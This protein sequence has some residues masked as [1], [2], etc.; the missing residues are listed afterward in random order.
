MLGVG[1]DDSQTENEEPLWKQLECIEQVAPDLAPGVTSS[2]QLL[3]G[4]LRI[5]EPEEV[6]LSFNG[7]KDATVVFH[8]TRAAFQ[9]LYKERKP[10][11]HIQAVFFEEPDP[12]EQFPEVLEFVADWSRRYADQLVFDRVPGG[13]FHG[14]KTYLTE[15]RPRVRCF[16]LGTR[17]IDPDGPSQE[18]LSPS[19]PEWPS[20]LRVNPILHWSYRAVWRFLRT[21][22]LEYCSLYDAG[23]TSIGRVS[24]TERNP[25]LRRESALFDDFTHL[26]RDED[27]RCG[28]KQKTKNQVQQLAIAHVE[29]RH[30]SQDPAQAALQRLLSVRLLLLGTD[31]SRW[32]DGMIRANLVSRFLREL[33]S[34]P[35][36]PQL[37]QVV[38]DWLEGLRLALATSLHGESAE[39]QCP[40]LPVILVA[41]DGSGSDV[42]LLR[43]LVEALACERLPAED[44]IRSAPNQ[45]SPDDDNQTSRLRLLVCPL[46]S[47]WGNPRHAAEALHRAID[48]STASPAR[49]LTPPARFTLQCASLRRCNVQTA[50][51]H[52]GL[53]SEPLQS[54]ILFTDLVDL[55]LNL[56]GHISIAVS[57]DARARFSQVFQQFGW[58]FQEA[59]APAQ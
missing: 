34:Y 55:R 27:E 29:H 36:K 16:L 2:L 23:Y 26:D 30:A 17:W 15:I 48:L 49:E 24:D 31:A 28:R 39:S 35:W 18:H 52:E 56:D 45:A 32:F 3:R 7:G 14:L 54:T 57:G 9:S 33:E 43:A 40:T 19:S 47:T 10:A 12:Q 37:V 25:L 6:A 41:Y 59:S 58:P 42:Q 13:I 1:K 51:L 20:F 50:R 44:A 22:H 11:P 53:I 21:F 8:L 46:G 4:V 38:T 5:F